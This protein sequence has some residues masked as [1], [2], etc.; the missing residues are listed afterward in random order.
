MIHTLIEKN[1][2]SNDLYKVRGKLFCFDMKEKKET[3][4]TRHWFCE[5]K[6]KFDKS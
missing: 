3:E 5:R 4:D 2:Y 6:S 1:T